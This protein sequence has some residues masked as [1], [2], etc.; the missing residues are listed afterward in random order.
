MAQSSHRKIQYP[1]LIDFGYGDPDFTTDKRITQKAFVDALSGHTHYTED[2]GD[3]E[4]REEIAKYYR[5]EFNYSLSSDQIMITTGSAHG[6]WL[7]LTGIL[8]PGDEVIIPT[9]Y[10]PPYSGQVEITG[11]KPIYL[12]LYEDEGFQLN[13]ERFEGVITNRTKAIIINSPNNPTGSI[14]N[15][16]TLESMGYLC[17]KYDLLIIS[18]EVYTIYNYDDEFIPIATVENLKKRT[19][20]LGSFSKDYAMAGWRVGYILAADDMI[21]LFKY[22]NEYN[23]YTAPSISQRA[24]LSALRLRKTIQPELREVFKQRLFYGYDRLRNMKNIRIGKPQGGFFLF[25][26]IEGTGLSSKEVAKVLLE[27]AHILVIPGTAFGQGGKGYIR[28]SCALNIDEM[29]EGF[30]RMERLTIFR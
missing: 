5:D 29:R 11:G 8:D 19:I 3:L 21:D 22:I 14:M 20:S 27:Q 10:Y 17:E 13:L 6:M 12:P 9:P 1:D 25:P 24:A 18:D 30:N 16:H 4:L 26:N 28:F 2:V 15:R 23:V 7:T